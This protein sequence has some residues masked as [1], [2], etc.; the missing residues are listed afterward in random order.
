MK[1]LLI[2]GCGYV[3]SYLYERLSATF[4]DLT[5]CDLMRRGNPLAINLI[6]S[7]YA[8]L[9]LDFLKDFDAVVWFAGH[10]SVQQSISDPQGALANNCLNLF[11]FSKKLSSK[12]KLIYASSG[13]LYSVKQGESYLPARENELITIPYQNAYDISKFAFDYLAENFLENFY[14]LRMGTVSGFSPNLRR[15][16]VFN[17]MNISAVLTGK[18]HVKN[19]NSLRSILFLDDLYLLVEKILLT[20]SEPG[21]YNA[22]SISSTIGEFAKE[23]AKTWNADVIDE[24]ISETYSFVLDSSKMNTLLDHSLSVKNLSERS[25]EFI[26]KCKKYKL[27]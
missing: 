9:E 24:G 20:N 10:S 17:A 18:V 2:G 4:S 5:V 13:S 14:G 26:K 6:Q 1:I 21:I 3:G 7:D 12:T 11:S 22:G 16:L 15:E 19:K 27:I 23:I 25:E 8:S